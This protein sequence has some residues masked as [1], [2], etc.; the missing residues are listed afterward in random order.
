MKGLR[1]VLVAL[2]VV[3][4]ASAGVTLAGQ[5][6]KIFTTKTQDAWVYVNVD[7]ARKRTKEGYIPLVV[8]V[9]N[10]SKNN[11]NLTR[12]SFKLIGP[13]GEEIP[14]A[15]VQ[16]IREGYPKLDLDYRWLQQVTPMRILG[17]R[18]VQFIP[19]HFYPG[20]YEGSSVVIN[21]VQLG[22]R[23]FTADILYFKKPKGF[24]TGT[25]VFEVTAK[26]WEHPVRVSIR[27]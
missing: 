5:S 3:S 2:V 4:L 22:Q 12:S 19:S 20:L 17:V 24:T 7:L 9:M 16:E 15:T 11:V 10:N 26:G 6:D 13:A 18:G 23:F 14:A 8:G 21:T 1:N 27:I 25:L